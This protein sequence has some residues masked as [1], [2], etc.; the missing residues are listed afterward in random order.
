MLHLDEHIFN[1]NTM[2]IK[3][4]HVGGEVLHEINFAWERAGI[5]KQISKWNADI[6]VVTTEC[7]VNGEI[8]E[9]TRKKITVGSHLEAVEGQQ[10]QLAPGMCFSLRWLPETSTSS[11]APGCRAFPTPIFLS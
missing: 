6:E 11:P 1:G 8:S 4:K 7:F 5:P 9:T 10:A 2:D 3:Y